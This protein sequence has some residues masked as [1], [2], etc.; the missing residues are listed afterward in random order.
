MPLFKKVN[1]TWAI[2]FKS[3]EKFIKKNPGSEDVIIAKVKEYILYKFVNNK[4]LMRSLVTKSYEEL[5]SFYDFYFQ[6]CENG[7]LI[8]FFFF[9]LEVMNYIDENRGSV[10][11]WQLIV[12]NN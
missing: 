2:S 7:T 4:E 3:I 12:Y 6:L 8:Q 5:D 10:K 9:F 1:D 11:K